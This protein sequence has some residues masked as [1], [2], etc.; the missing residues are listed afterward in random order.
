M[1]SL[2]YYIALGLGL[3]CASLR[4][5][6]FGSTGA[7][8]MA[9][10]LAVRPQGMAQAFS[11]LADDESSLQ[12]NPAGLARQQGL[13]LGG[14]QVLGL[15]DDR[16]SLVHG[17]WRVGSAV[18]IGFQAAFASAEDQGRNAFGV[19]TGGFS[20]R[21]T[22]AGLGLGFEPLPGWRFGFAAKGLLEDLGGAQSQ[23][24]AGD[25]GLQVDLAQ[26]WRAGAALLNAGSVDAG[27][28]TRLS[29]PMRVQ[30]G[31]SAPFFTPRWQVEADLQELPVEEQLRLLLGTEIGFSLDEGAGEG[32]QRPTRAALRGGAVAGLLKNEALRLSLGAS[33]GFGPH[34]TLD[35]ALQDSGVLG[36]THRFSLSLRFS[37]SA[38][39]SAHVDGPAAA[40]LSAPYA[41]EVTPQFDG[42]LIRWQHDDQAVKGY[43]LYSDY[44]VLVERLNAE[45]LDKT[46]QRFI[47]VTR[48]RTY[49]FYVRP[50]GADGQEGPPSQIKTVRVK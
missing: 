16:I 46:A 24:V 29:T 39:A 47:K 11:A 20:D 38:A 17:A 36:Q 35:Y 13:S 2:P 27:G 22:L 49:N 28:G 7:L 42:L 5:G 8:L 26:G 6:G 4:A 14:A 33:L 19:E 45:P 1:R 41:L 37:P 25:A 40:E 43:N 10:G 44:G 12:A 50:I 15:L 18:G 32:S 9:E 21:Q 34:F 48:S 31:V 23:A 3:A 30:A